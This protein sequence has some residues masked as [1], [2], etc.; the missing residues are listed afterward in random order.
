MVFLFPP[1]PLVK[2]SMYYIMM[3]LCSANMSHMCSTAAR[4]TEGGA[5][6]AVAHLAYHHA[7][8]SMLRG[9]NT[10]WYWGDPTC[11]AAAAAAAA[12]TTTAAAAATASAAAAAT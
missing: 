5:S 4:H 8:C 7:T 11:K 9:I 12:A 1:L 2:W 10:T 6:Q 3:M